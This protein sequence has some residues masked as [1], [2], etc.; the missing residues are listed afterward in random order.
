MEFESIFTAAQFELN[1]RIKNPTKKSS[2]YDSRSSDG[3]SMDL[4]TKA[5]QE[6]VRGTA[7]MEG[8]V[9]GDD[10][11]DLSGEGVARKKY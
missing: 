1:N 7:S 9:I 2:V 10:L 8:L 11:L 5:I 6:S 3:A 4:V